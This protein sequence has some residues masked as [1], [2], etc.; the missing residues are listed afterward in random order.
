MN[1]IEERLWNYIDGNCTADEKQAIS[2]LIAQDD[3]YKQLYQQLLILNHDI[4]AIKPDEPSMAFTYN[5]MEAIRTDYALK[6]LKA[7]I[8]HRIIKGITAF[9]I[10]TI[11]AILVFV[12]L[13]IHF[14]SA[15]YSSKITTGINL[16]Q[17]SNLTSGIFM[18]GFLIFDVVLALFLVDAW[19]RKKNITK[20]V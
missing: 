13:N 4:M 6:P 17:I 8:D 10:L 3:E 12:F 15:S 5:V 16:S 18:K 9:F 2:L 1:S 19:M 7:T 20:S 14:Q 11:A